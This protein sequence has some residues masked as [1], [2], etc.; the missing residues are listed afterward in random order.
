MLK[1]GVYNYSDV[2][3]RRKEAISKSSQKTTVFKV[4]KVYLEKY[5]FFNLSKI[6]FVRNFVI[7]I[8]V[9]L[10]ILLG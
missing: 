3:L 9:K 4:D 8:A 6:F 1:P 5:F 7:R 2:S 10:L